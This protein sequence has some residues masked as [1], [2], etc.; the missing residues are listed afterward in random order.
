MEQAPGFGGLTFDPFS[1]F[2]NGLAATE[3]A[4][5][6]GEVLHVLVIA[7]VVVMLEK[8]ID[9]LP[10]IA[11]QEIA[12]QQDLVIKPRAIDRSSS[13]FADDAVRLENDPSTGPSANRPT[14]RRCNW[15]RCR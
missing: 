13:K 15:P 12:F 14:R 1:L 7:L 3:G 5:G 8:D 9:L 10:E 6:S 11:G 2:Q 4:I